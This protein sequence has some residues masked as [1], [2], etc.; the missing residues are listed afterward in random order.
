MPIDSSGGSWIQAHRPSGKG[1]RL[2]PFAPSE[3]QILIEVAARSI[4]Y[5]CRYSGNLLTG[6]R[7]PWHAL[8]PE[9]K[10]SKD[11]GVSEERSIE[12]TFGDNIYSVGQHTM[13]VAWALLCSVIEQNISCPVE[14]VRNLRSVRIGL[15]HDLTEGCG[16]VDIPW[17]VKIKLK[18]YH[19]IEDRIWL[20]FMQYDL[21]ESLPENVLEWDTRICATEKR[22]FIGVSAGH[23]RQDD[24]QPLPL[25]I[26]PLRPLA[27]YRAWMRM[28]RFL[29][30]ADTR[31]ASLVND[32]TLTRDGAR[33]AILALYRPPARLAFYNRLRYRVGIRY[34]YTG[35]ELYGL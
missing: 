17:P 3:D 4:C 10:E 19:E 34:M 2:Y 27:C 7:R 35:S 28:W 6:V 26:R 22:D 16:I 32:Q 31:A 23:W 25:R 5:L 1:F 18:E 21:P 11:I 13:L 14:L 33:Q 24:M 15:A 8:R 29:R 30:A 9:S 12:N 20:K